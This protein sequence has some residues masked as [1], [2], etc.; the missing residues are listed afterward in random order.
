MIAREKCDAG[1]KVFDL[2]GGQ[3]GAG[4]E[5]DARQVRLAKAI[6]QGADRRAIEGSRVGP[7]A[8]NNWLAHVMPSPRQ[9]SPT[10]ASYLT[11]MS[12]PTH[13]LLL[14]GPKLP[15]S[16]P[17]LISS[18]LIRWTRG[19]ARLRCPST[20]GVAGLVVQRS[21]GIHAVC[22]FTLSTTRACSYPC[23]SFYAGEWDRVTAAAAAPVFLGPGTLGSMLPASNVLVVA[24]LHRQ[25]GLSDMGCRFI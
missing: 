15:L 9:R 18:R 8:A 21:F 13:M 4:R 12:F 16:N 2:E 10:G 1:F 17:V 6:T 23:S 22:A 3:E 20:T 14:S 25:E 7:P 11:A 19:A 24:V 5:V